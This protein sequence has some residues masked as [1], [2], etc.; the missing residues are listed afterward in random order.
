MLSTNFLPCQLKGY[1]Y[2]LSTIS[3][4]QQVPGHVTRQGLLN[5]VVRG[6]RGLG[7]NRTLLHSI[8]TIHA[9]ST[10]AVNKPSRSFTRHKGQAVWL[11]KILKA[12]C[13]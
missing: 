12:A 3:S 6:R 13:P 7:L 1:S 5:G 10:R 2:L 11:A 8:Y 4:Y 9:V